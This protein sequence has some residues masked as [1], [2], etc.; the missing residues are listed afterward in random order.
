[1]TDP[2]ARL[3]QLYADNY[4]RIRGYALRR[5]DTVEDAHDVVSETF[6]VAWRRLDDVPDGD[7]AVLW[8]YGTARKVLSNQHRSNRRRRRLMH[9]LRS[10]PPPPIHVPSAHEPDTQRVA[11]AFARLT[12]DDQEILVLTGWE[13]LDP[14]QLAI[15]L[16]CA[17]S[18]ARV[19]LHRA[20]KRFAA[21]LEAEGMRSPR[22]QAQGTVRS[23]AQ[24]HESEET[25]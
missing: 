5:T 6:L 24:G 23:L 1:M 22:A 2:R 25:P 20:R 3:E 8:L 14:G 13:Q 18:T 9:R 19:R 17:R 16:E 12:P 11:T 7:R 10:Q 21:A 4:E 15:V